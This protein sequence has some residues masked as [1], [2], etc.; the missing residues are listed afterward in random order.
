MSR[1][2]LILMPIWHIGRLNRNAYPKNAC[3]HSRQ[4][5][6]RRWL[7]MHLKRFSF[8]ARSPWKI[9]CA[10]PMAIFRPTRPSFLDLVPSSW[11]LQQLPR[12]ESLCWSRMHPSGW[13]TMPRETGL[14]IVGLVRTDTGFDSIRS[15][16]RRILLV[17][18]RIFFAWIRR[19]SRSLEEKRLWERS[20][21]RR[22]SVERA[23]F[24]ALFR[25]VFKRLLSNPSPFCPRL[26]FEQKKDKYEVKKIDLWCE[27]DIR[28]LIFAT[29]RRKV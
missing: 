26:V 12:S 8:Q 9:C 14:R 17:T 1:F 18:R 6:S 2:E 24:V 27:I 15:C 21:T 19:R 5:M 7:R 11:V 3:M 16:S 13:A 29:A 20:D 28:S 25:T 10:D 23:P 22:A 4:S